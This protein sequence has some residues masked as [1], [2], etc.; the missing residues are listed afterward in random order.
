VTA[1][2]AGSRTK[3]DSPLLLTTFSHLRYSP[4]NRYSSCSKSLF[5]PRYC[6]LLRCKPAYTLRQEPAQVG[7]PIE[8]LRAS[9]A[10]S[11]ASSIGQSFDGPAVSEPLAGE[12]RRVD[13]GRRNPR[14][15][16]DIAE[17]VAQGNPEQFELRVLGGETPRQLLSR[18]KERRYFEFPLPV[19]VYD[20]LSRD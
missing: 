19:A 16:L 15:F 1:R 13:Q 5:L 7:T 10:A 14:F 12:A 6:L 3:W 8:F 17:S 2:P 20:L 9:P 4:D 18:A 11:R